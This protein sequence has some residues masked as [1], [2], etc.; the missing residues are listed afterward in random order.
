MSGGLQN[1]ASGPITGN[2]PASATTEVAEAERWLVILHTIPKSARD[3]AERRQ[4]QYRDRGLQVEI[5]DTD[6]FPRLVG[7]SWII[8]QGPFDSRAQALE[9]ANTAKEFNSNLMVR[10]AL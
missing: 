3:E 8:A 10:R 4:N 6:A 5:M 2:P 9:A 1:P 7:G